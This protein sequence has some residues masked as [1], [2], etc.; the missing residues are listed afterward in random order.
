MVLWNGSLG[1]LVLVALGRVEQGKGGF[2]EAPFDFVGP[3]SLEELETRGRIAFGACLLM[4]RQTWREDQYELRR[5]AREQRRA[6]AKR[7]SSLLQRSAGDEARY[8]DILD[9]PLDGVLAPSEVKAAFRRLAK[10]THPDRGGSSEQFHRIIEARDA[11]L[12]R[13]GEAAP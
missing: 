10:T 7:L 13:A 9:L 8:R 5:D 12:E 1:M 6:Q 4:K 2:L 11:L 3:F